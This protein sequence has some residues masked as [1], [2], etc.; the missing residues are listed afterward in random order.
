ME[1]EEQGMADYCGFMNAH[2]TVITELL[3]LNYFS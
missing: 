2:R 1:I 3:G